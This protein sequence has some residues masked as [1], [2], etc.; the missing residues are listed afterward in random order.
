MIN[1]TLETMK[2]IEFRFKDVSPTDIL[3][4]SN[5]DF[6]T[7]TERKELYDFAL[8]NTE[9]KM[10]EK[11]VPVKTPAIQPNQ[12]DVYMPIGMEKNLIEMEMICTKFLV[13]V[14]YKA[15]QKSSE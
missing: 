1:F 12:R 9:V 8:E 4:L 15:F 10:G 2:D 5:M 7:R 14:V 6:K 13:E 11:W 3:S